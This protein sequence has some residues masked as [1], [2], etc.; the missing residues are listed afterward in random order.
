MADS[1]QL[2]T[3]MKGNRESSYRQRAPRFHPTENLRYWVLKSNYIKRRL[4]NQDTVQKRKRR[5][6]LERK[7][8]EVEDFFRSVS[9]IQY[10]NNHLLEEQPK[11]DT[12]A[13]EAVFIPQ[14]YATSVD[15]AFEKFMRETGLQ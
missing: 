2:S 3:S 11:E 14:E 7:R 12:G 13:T 10:M 15:S 4:V 6:Q 9:T 5:Q 1:V 8:Q